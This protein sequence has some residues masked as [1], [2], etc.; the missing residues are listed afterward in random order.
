[1]NSEFKVQFKLLNTKFKILVNGIL[2]INFIHYFWDFAHLRLPLT[3][4]SMLLAVLLHGL[5][6]FSIMTFDAPMN[7]ILPII[8]V[9]A[10]AL[11]MVYDFDEIKKIKSICKI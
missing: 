1:M 7:F 9:L 11:F 10:L 3:V 8:I 4:I 5:Y 6:D 2:P